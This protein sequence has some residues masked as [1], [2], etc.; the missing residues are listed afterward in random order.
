[1][2]LLLCN[3]SHL[4]L[5]LMI[6]V[7]VQSSYVVCRPAAQN[8]YLAKLALVNNLQEKYASSFNESD[9]FDEENIP[10]AKFPNQLTDSKHIKGKK[11]SQDPR[12]PVHLL[13]IP[14]KISLSSPLATKVGFAEVDFSPENTEIIR[15]L[16]VSLLK[17]LL[18]YLDTYSIQVKWKD[19]SGKVGTGKRR[20]AN[21]IRTSSWTKTTAAGALAIAAVRDKHRDLI[22][23][24]LTLVPDTTTMILHGKASA[25]VD[26]QLA[27][28]SLVDLLATTTAT[29]SRQIASSSQSIAQIY[30]EYWAEKSSDALMVALTSLVLKTSS[31]LEKLKQPF[32][33]KQKGILLGAM[34]AGSLAH[35]KNIKSQDEQRLW[36]INSISNLAWASATFLGAI[37][38]SASITASIAGSLSVAA[39]TWAVIH[40]KVGARDFTPTVKEIEGHIEFTA[41]EI[42]ESHNKRS[43][44][45]DIL[46][47]LQWMHATIHINGHFD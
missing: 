38:V 12:Y 13:T 19:A 45:V 47:T 4:T 5:L 27:A 36:L 31:L 28:Q 22:G 6:I 15:H 24:L 26:V 25:A 43:F 17:E 3:S 34:L 18:D 41:L 2:L 40:N 44:M 35:C 20:L 8:P 37:P 10:L 23:T 46:E 11:G 30:I 21:L 29:N 16:P 1:M 14:R 9:Q 39:V 42:A 32:T 33:L 7:S